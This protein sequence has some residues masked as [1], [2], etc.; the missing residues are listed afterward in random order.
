MAIQVF[1]SNQI[2]SAVE[3][4]FSAYRDEFAAITRSAQDRFKHR[5]WD[6]VQLA[7]RDRIKLYRHHADATAAK[8]AVLLSQGR[9]DLEDWHEARDRYVQLV[10]HR[11]DAELAGTVFNTIYRRT[12][13]HEGIDERFAFV[14]HAIPSPETTVPVTR[15]KT[16]DGLTNLLRQVFANVDL[17]ADFEDQDRDVELIEKN[18]KSLIPLLRNDVEQ[19][20]EIELLKPVF[21]RNKGAYLIGRMTIDGHVFP[22]AIPILNSRDGLYVDT[23]IWNENDLSTIF[24]FTRSYFFVDIESPKAMVTYLNDLLPRKKAWELFTSLGYY[25]HGKT[26]FYSDFLA[27]LDQSDDQFVVAEGI[28]GMVMT[29]FTL[30]SYQTVFKVIK[31]KFSPT[32]TV[33]RQGVKDAYYLVKTHDR[34]GRMAD[35]QEFSDLY[36]PRDR[37]DPAL[38]EELQKVAAASI[39]LTDAH[40]IV[41]HVYTERLMTP[42]NL[43][44]RDKSEFELRLVLEDYGHAIKQLAA[45]NIFPGDMLLK[46]FGVT[47]HGR[48]VFYDYDEICYLTDVY[49]RDFPVSQHPEDGMSS[50]PWFSVAD[51]DVFPQEFQTFLFSS[52]AL[53]D[54]FSEYHGELFTAAYWRA[55]QDNVRNAKVIDV[56]PYRQNRRFGQRAVLQQDQDQLKLEQQQ[57]EQQQK[58]QQQKEQQQKE[59]Q[60]KEQQQQ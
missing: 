55:L 35:T 6:E 37:F 4:G 15:Y 57:K 34:V 54:L 42:L 52:P 3:V 38:I 56:F 7:S 9:P 48:V 12:H 44:I 40:V 1:S 31:D 23:I 26:E 27:H 33:T 24:S 60:Q 29:V 32:K 18:M 16:S 45:A 39:K 43:Y 14:N 53:S 5:A 13:L 36:L 50:A 59:Q 17:G 41:Q 28:K 10:Q 58:E 11:P 20:I 25:K 46:N 47:R 51:A 2:A 22:L 49:F 8:L 21:Y 19:Q 30:P